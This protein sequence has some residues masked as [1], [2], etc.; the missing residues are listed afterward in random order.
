MPADWNDIAPDRPIRLDYGAL[1]QT[2]SQA[3]L[4]LAPPTMQIRQIRRARVQEPRSNQPRRDVAG[5]DRSS[6]VFAVRRISI[7]V[8][9]LLLRL[10]PGPVGRTAFGILPQTAKLPGAPSS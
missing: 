6:V 3:R 4:G 9:E 10:L 8:R 7:S 5:K 2:A 1:P